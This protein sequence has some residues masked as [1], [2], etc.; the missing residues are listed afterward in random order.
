MSCYGNRMLLVRAVG[1]LLFELFV[2]QVSFNALCS[3]L[4]IKNI[5]FSTRP[6]AKVCCLW[7]PGASRVH[8]LTFKLKLR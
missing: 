1:V 5:S 4:N 8:P 2:S 3:K 7:H 6:K